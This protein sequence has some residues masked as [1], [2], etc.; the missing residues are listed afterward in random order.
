MEHMISKTNARTTSRYVLR[1]VIAVAAIVAD[2][3]LPAGALPAPAA[4]Q[5]GANSGSADSLVGPQVWYFQAA[6]GPFVVH[7]DATGTSQDSAPV[8]GAFAV[9]VAFSPNV[10]GDRFRSTPSGSGLIVNGTVTRPTR[11]LITIVPPNSPLVRVARNYTIEATGNIAFGSGSSA[12]PVVGPYI[13]KRGYGATRFNANGTIVTA[14]G[15][16][17][18]WVVFDPKLR[19]YTV[20][21]GTDRMTVKLVP[22][23]GLIDA[24][25]ENLYFE[26]A[27]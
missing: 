13:S 12:D 24:S 8:G 14:D 10:K 26:S 21:I 27:R 6:P 11:V 16:Q 25:N 17:G 1:S 18:R 2:A 23:R 7:I 22:G 3:A 5:A 20:T 19:I 15:Q 4:L 9:R